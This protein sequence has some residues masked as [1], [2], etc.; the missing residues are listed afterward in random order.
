MGMCSNRLR[1]HFIAIVQLI[2]VH[3]QV[4]GVTIY[5]GV[6]YGGW[7]EAALRFLATRFDA[8][9]RSFPADTTGAVRCFFSCS[10][11]CFQQVQAA[12]AGYC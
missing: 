10:G 6:R 3:S 11:T 4:T 1:F 12:R 8:A 5:V 2:C 9:A 7:Q